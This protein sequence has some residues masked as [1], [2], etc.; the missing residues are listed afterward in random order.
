[1]KKRKNV[2]GAVVFLMT[3]GVATADALEFEVAKTQS[4]G[5]CLAWIEVLQAAGHNVES[6][7]LPMATLLQHKVKNGIGPDMTSCHTAKV[8]GYTI[9][10]H[11]PVED[12]ERLV[13]EKPD[14]IGL[15]VPGMPVGSPGMEY[16]ETRDAFDVYLVKADGTT[17]VFN[18]YRAVE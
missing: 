3:G 18:S 11:V 15:A 2:I 9:E 16:G 5:C 17:E 10:G 6:R 8:A 1:M 13:K 12:I 7:N 14:A 4:C